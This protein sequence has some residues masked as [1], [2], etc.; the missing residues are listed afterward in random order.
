MGSPITP[1]PM[2][3]RVCASL[4]RSSWGS[5]IESAAWLDLAE[6]GP[7]REISAARSS[8]DSHLAKPIA[9]EALQEPP[10]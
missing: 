3:P 6:N 7:M 9:P 8:L 2:K 4:M 5:S 1:V 10:A